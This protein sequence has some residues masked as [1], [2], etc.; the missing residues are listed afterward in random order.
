M[1]GCARCPRQT[2]NH[3]CKRC[4]IERAHEHQQ[5]DHYD[6]LWDCPDCGGV[7][8]DYYSECPRQ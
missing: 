3:L 1:S 7:H 6:D 4:R 2:P 5:D 8:S